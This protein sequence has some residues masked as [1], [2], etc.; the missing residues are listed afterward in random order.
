MSLDPQNQM[1]L[2]VGYASNLNHDDYNQYCRAS[3][4]SLSKGLLL[5]AS[6]SYCFQKI[7]SVHQSL[8]WKKV[9]LHINTGVT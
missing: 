7:L 1:L 2:C 9:N 4:D 3:N 6:Q 8:L 5:L